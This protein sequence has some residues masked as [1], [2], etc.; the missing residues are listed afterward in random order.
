MGCPIAHPRL[1]SNPNSLYS[2]TLILI[3]QWH[4]RLGGSFVASMCFS[5]FR[6]WLLLS[7][8]ENPDFA[9]FLPNETTSS[10]NLDRT[11]HDSTHWHQSNASESAPTGQFGDE[12]T[13]LK[14]EPSL[15]GILKFGSSAPRKP[16]LLPQL[17]CLL[18]PM[19]ASTY[20]LYF[21]IQW[22]YAIPT[23]IK[24]LIVE[25]PQSRNIF[26]AAFLKHQA[27]F[28]S[29]IPWAKRSFTEHQHFRTDF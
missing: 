22:A 27:R 23:S 26:M 11:D 15:R 13:L 29:P 19:H 24:D 6:T 12:H 4:L 5:Q 3:R 10:L 1:A 16:D 20:K 17:S 25:T 8:P 7:A 28:P 18:N 14:V 21:N 9:L 2:L